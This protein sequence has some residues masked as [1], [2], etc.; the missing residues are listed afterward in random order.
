V[1]Q[2]SQLLSVKAKDS[3]TSPFSMQTHSSAI[4]T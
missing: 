2:R 1:M 4:H 3:L